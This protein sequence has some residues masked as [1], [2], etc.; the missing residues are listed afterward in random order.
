LR[1]PGVTSRIEELT[2]GSFQEII[3]DPRGVTGARRLV[4]CCGKVY[5]D[6]MEKAVA[7]G[8]DDVAIVRVEQLYPFHPEKWNE[9][10]ERY[11]NAKE[12]VWVSEEP[13]NY[14]AWEFM[15]QHLESL[16]HGALW[17][18]GRARSAS[19]AVGSK[20]A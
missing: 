10:S 11:E 8:T 7:N 13:V 17:Y 20:R 2:T 12:W 3:D 1:R 4:L 9:I 15:V 5:Y 6:L 16:Y 14:G 19:P 18:V